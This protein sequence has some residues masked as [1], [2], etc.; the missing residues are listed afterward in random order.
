M[1]GSPSPRHAA[2]FASGAFSFDFSGSF[3]VNI[4]QAAIWK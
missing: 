1:F 2:P 3:N 4:S